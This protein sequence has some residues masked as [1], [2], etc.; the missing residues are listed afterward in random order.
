MWQIKF[1]TLKNIPYSEKVTRCIEKMIT[2]AQEAIAL[3]ERS[4]PFNKTKKDFH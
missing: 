1:F 2:L 4:H 3:V